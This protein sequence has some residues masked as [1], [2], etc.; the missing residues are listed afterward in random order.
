MISLLRTNPRTAQQ[1]GTDGVVGD[2]EQG[3]D[4][5]DRNTGSEGTT[6]TNDDGSVVDST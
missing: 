2:R 1:P 6:E 3:E 4:G 5:T